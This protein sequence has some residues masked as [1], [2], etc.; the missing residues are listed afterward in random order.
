M[1]DASTLL[2]ENFE[3]SSSDGL[4][5]AEVTQVQYLPLENSLKI[6]ISADDISGAGPYKV[7]SYGIADCYG[8]TAD[9]EQNT[10]LEGLRECELYD[11]SI[12]SVFYRDSERVYIIQPQNGNFETVIRIVNSS[13]LTKYKKLTIY[14]ENTEGFSREIFECDVSL[15]G[16]TMQE[17]IHN[18][19]VTDKER[20]YAVLE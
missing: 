15:A 18:T 3:V 1:L 19:I 17:I 6:H 11:I 16:N 13:N 7:T 10:Y 12:Q 4:N 2:K 14:G 8:N 20:I 5:L 9:F